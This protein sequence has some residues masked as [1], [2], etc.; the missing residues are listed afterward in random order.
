VRRALL[1]IV[2]LFA[3][4]SVARA[5]PPDEPIGDGHFGRVR[6][7]WE[8]EAPYHG[9]GPV[10]LLLDNPDTKPHEIRAVV[11]SGSTQVE[12]TVT[13]APGA[14]RR[15][16]F[17]V[18][19]E[20]H[21]VSV[22]LAE[23]SK[24]LASSEHTVATFSGPM[25]LVVD[26]DPGSRGVAPVVS[27]VACVA[28]ALEEVPSELA[29][30]ASFETIVV[31]RANPARAGEGVRGVLDDYVRSGGTVVVVPDS[32][33]AET[34]TFWEQVPGAPRPRGPLLQEKRRGLGRVLLAPADP[35]AATP[36]ALALSKALALELDLTPRRIF[37]R[38][39]TGEAPNE[40]AHR[41]GRLLAIF[42]ALYFVV[43]GPGLARRLR[44]A[45]PE[46]VVRAVAIVV[47]AFAGLAVLLAR[48]VRHQVSHVDA[49]TFVVVPE[50]GEAM[51][52]T[53]V[54]V[55]SGGAARESIFLEGEDVS[56]T[57]INRNS[58]FFTIDYR[59]GNSPVWTPT[60]ATT[61]R[62]FGQHTV[63]FEDLA[64]PTLG[65]VRVNAI[66]RARDY[67][68]LEASIEV[69]PVTGERSARVKNTSGRTLGT[70][71][72]YAW[73]YQSE[74]LAARFPHGLEPGASAVAP[75][76][77]RTG[78]APS[79]VGYPPG[80]GPPIGWASLAPQD[81]DGG[82][83]R[84]V[85]VAEDEPPLR[86]TAKEVSVRQR[87]WR[88]EA[89]AAP[90]SSA[91]L[92]GNVGL[93]VKPWGPGVVVTASSSIFGERRVK[94]WLPSVGTTIFAV[95]GLP[96]RS[97]EELDRAFAR[98]EVDGWVEISTSDLRYSV[99]VGPPVPPAKLPLKKGQLEPPPEEE[100]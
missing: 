81:R 61:R 86:A 31:R 95:G 49:V 18:P 24:L 65:D 36:E 44:G 94:G 64:V 17:V 46:R 66:S 1:L 84:Y 43:A 92:P 26:G 16:P 32:A 22:A 2:F 25:I 13:L 60:S 78:G 38:F 89:V 100:E 58:P 12:A 47:V 63:A 96:V 29:C 21:R 93:K 67:R 52:A 37:P 42:F 30:L 11:A 35:C 73:G 20:S 85:L 88:V 69:D 15:V 76:T 50:V 28:A 59:N 51:A 68:P 6:L 48:S 19:L 83:P 80:L 56:A 87:A 45:P 77:T 75:I 23:G 34:R 9:L 41:A 10:S 3:S 91:T 97:Q 71:A 4:A 39:F 40:A 72:V 54:I 90:V 79:L 7:G 33:D 70:I 57:A 82:D 53:E 98:V 62:A 8:G 99:Q 27:G 74:T 55:R 5:A 14:K